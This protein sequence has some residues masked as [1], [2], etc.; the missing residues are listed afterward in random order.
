MNESR[1]SVKGHFQTAVIVLNPM[2]AVVGDS[3]RK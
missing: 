2:W 1:F 3:R